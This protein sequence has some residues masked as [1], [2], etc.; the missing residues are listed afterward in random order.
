[1][2]PEPRSRRALKGVQSVE[3]A[4]D[5]LLHFVHGSSF[6]ASELRAA[7]K[8]SRPTLYR[9]LAAMEKKKVLRSYG[10][11]RRYELGARV[12]ELANAW[13]SQSD[14]TRTSSPFLRDLW[15]S[16]GETIVLSV[17]HDDDVRLAIQQFR[18]NS[19]LSY[20]PGIGKAMPL[21]AGA[22]SKAILAFLAP[23]RV[24]A[25][26]A[27][28]PRKLDRKKLVDELARIRQR[29]FAV[30]TGE[31]VPGAASVAAPIF[32]HAATVVGSLALALPLSR[33]S[34]PARERHI[35]QVCQTARLISEALGYEPA[36]EPR[37]K[38]R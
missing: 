36:A 9:L 34:R 23:E 6:E 13:L 26:V 33:L 3:R 11:P 22:S 18:S 19:P 8:L 27:G 21:Y 1:M 20:A 31:L 15:E 5:I 10:Q 29:G 4:L 37:S 32:D 28:A 17:V 2:E 25:I 30:S 7:V 24:K 38:P 12:I 35:V 14:L 16:S